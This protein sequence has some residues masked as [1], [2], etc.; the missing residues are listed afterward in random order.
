MVEL[1]PESSKLNINL[2]PPE[3]MFRLLVNLGVEPGRAR[4]IAAA[5]LDW[6]S[7]VPGGMSPFDQY[8]LSL[9]PSFRARHASFQEIEELLLVKGM[10]PEIFHGSFA[11]DAQG[12]LVPQGGLKNCV[13]VYGMTTG[14]SGAVDVNSAEPAV[15]ATIGLSPGMVAALVERRHAM[16]FRNVQQLQAFAQAGGPGVERLTVGG[17]AAWT[18]RATSQIRLPDG[19]LSDLRRTVSAMVKFHK[20]G[21]NPVFEIIRWY[22]N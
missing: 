7:Y 17:G 18:L 21:H 14:S 20:P 9:V 5:I 4:E 13:T 6:R 22:D 2:T 3:E 19:R 12:R 16:P 1:I 15:L 11:R 8:Y 10:T